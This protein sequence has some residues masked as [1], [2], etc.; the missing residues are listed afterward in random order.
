MALVSTNI[1]A[2]DTITLVTTLGEIVATFV[3][4]SSSVIRVKK[5][6][7]VTGTS[8]VADTGQTKAL[9]AKLATTTSS[10]DVVDLNTARILCVLVTEESIA[11]QY[12]NEVS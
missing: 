2:D 10:T 7:K 1:E 5:P 8:S 3:S 4:E 9:W 6:M 12:S 11:T